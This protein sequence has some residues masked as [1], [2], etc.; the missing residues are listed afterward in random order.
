MVQNA[1]KRIG[2]NTTIIDIVTPQLIQWLRLKP[3]Y[4]PDW[5]SPI[6]TASNGFE[7]AL[8]DDVSSKLSHVVI[9]AKIK[10]SV[11]PSSV[12]PS[13]PARCKALVSGV[14]LR[15]LDDTKH[16]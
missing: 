5:S 15:D 7:V 1:K 16:P 13:A 6:E 10:P 2:T 9:Q 14:Q 12:P 3:T 4:N 8:A 11:N